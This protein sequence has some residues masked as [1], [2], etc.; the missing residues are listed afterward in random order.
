MNVFNFFESE[1]PQYPKYLQYIFEV[2]DIATE[3]VMLRVLPSDLICAKL[4]Y[5]NRQETFSTKL[6]QKLGE[7]V[8]KLWIKE[9]PD[10]KMTMSYHLSSTGGKWNWDSVRDTVKQASLGKKAANDYV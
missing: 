1:L 6:I 7:K 9:L 5:P 3:Y 4:F 2:K 8:T 10:I